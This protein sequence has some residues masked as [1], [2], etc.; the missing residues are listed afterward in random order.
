MFWVNVLFIFKLC[1]VYIKLILKCEMP[2]F[3]IMEARKW[4]NIYR[5][6]AYFSATLG[7]IV[8]S[9]MY[10]LINEFHWSLNYEKHFAFTLCKLK[11]NKFKISKC[12]LYL[13][14]FKFEKY[15]VFWFLKLMYFVWKIFFRCI[16]L[17]SEYLWV[18]WSN[19]VLQETK[20]AVV[21]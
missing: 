4:I 20:S 5:T 1:T 2:N 9:S 19:Y 14:L 3:N 18:K 13:E 12:I 21:N 15:F 7:R 11:H 8:R 10:T 17:N 6:S 16:L